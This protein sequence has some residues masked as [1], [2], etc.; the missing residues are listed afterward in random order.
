MLLLPF[1]PRLGFLMLTRGIDSAPPGAL[2]K[3]GGRHCSPA[4]VRFT[5]L[6]PIM[7]DIQDIETKFDFT[8]LPL[9]PV[10]DKF[11]RF[12]NDNPNVLIYAPLI[13]GFNKF[14]SKIDCIRRMRD[15]ILP[16]VNPKS[17]SEKTVINLL[18]AI[19]ARP[20]ISQIVEWVIKEMRKNEPIVEDESEVSDSDNET[21]H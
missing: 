4:T 17:Y 9:G 11:E 16:N 13:D 8:H 19:Y 10:S 15:Y 6:D 20:T 5:I 3:R 14:T 21:E 18:F 7:A 12:L 2:W 1:G